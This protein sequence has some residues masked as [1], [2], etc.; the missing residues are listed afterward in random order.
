MVEHVLDRAHFGAR[1]A[2]AKALGPFA[3]R[4]ARQ[5]LAHPGHQHGGL[6]GALFDGVVVRVFGQLRQ[7]QVAAQRAPEVRRVGRQVQ[8]AVAG[9]MDAGDAARAHVALDVARF[10]IGPDQAGRLHRQRA[11]QQRDLDRLPTACLL[12]AVEGRRHAVGDQGGA[13][14]VDH[15]AVQHFGRTVGLGLGGAH[16]GHR[17]QHLVVAGVA[18]HRA[19]RAIT[20]HGAIDQARVDRRQ[21]GEVDTQALGHARPEVVDQ[22]VGLA[23]QAQQDLVA[24][25]FLQVQAQAALVAVDAQEGAAFAGQRR[26]VLAQVVAFGRLDL[27][28]VG[29]HVAQEGAAIGAGDVGAQV[30]DLDAGQ[31]QVGG[32]CLLHCGFTQNR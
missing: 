20:G 16:A 32:G 25:G 23:H 14:V 19:D 28:D 1:H 9:G 7:V 18:R 22:H 24:G 13:V 30:Q 10:A 3:R 6:G 8:V 21:R 26:R 27:D 29:A 12:A 5:R 31:R 15:G 2:L 4:G 17:L 11:A